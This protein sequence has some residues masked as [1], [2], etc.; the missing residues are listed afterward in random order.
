MNKWTLIAVIIAATLLKTGTLYAQSGWTLQ[1]CLNYA[2]EHNIQLQKSRISQEDSKEQLLQ[3]VHIAHKIRDL[4]EVVL[5]E[6][7]VFQFLEIGQD[8]WNLF[9]IVLVENQALGLFQVGKRFGQGAEFVLAQVHALAMQPPDVVGQ[10]LDAV[11]ANDDL[12]DLGE[13]ADV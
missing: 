3:A 6:I 7:Q 10:F 9:K 12:L 2:A 13:V 4:G 8:L 11:A 5:V 1:Q